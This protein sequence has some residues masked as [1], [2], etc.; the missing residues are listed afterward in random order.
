MTISPVTGA[1]IE[2]RAGPPCRYC[3]VPMLVRYRTWFVHAYPPEWPHWAAPVRRPTASDIPASA[4]AERTTPIA[5]GHRGV[6]LSRNLSQSAS[7]PDG[8]A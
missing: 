3:G 8:T 6:G 5:A 4:P 7:A 1:P 2:R